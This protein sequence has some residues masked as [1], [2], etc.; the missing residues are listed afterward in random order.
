MIRIKP[1]F[2]GP[3]N[4]QILRELQELKEKAAEYIKGTSDSERFLI[5]EKG[6]CYFPG[7]F[8]YN[9]FWVRM[10]FS[11]RQPPDIMSLKF[12]AEI[13]DGLLLEW[14]VRWHGG[15]AWAQESELNL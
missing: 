14:K 13:I 8:M 5:T 12:V 11:L 9:N 3:G 2:Y 4:Y 1:E 10:P 6:G 7:T 15:G